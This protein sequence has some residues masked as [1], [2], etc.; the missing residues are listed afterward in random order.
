MSALLCMQTLVFSQA[1]KL[2][3][4]A[5]RTNG[6]ITVDGN[7]NEPEWQKAEVARNFTQTSPRPGE[8]S[9]QKSEVRIL[10]DNNAVYVGATLYDDKQDSVYR[11]LSSRDDDG[12]NVDVF[13]VLFD[14]YYDKQNAAA[15][16]VTAAGVQLDGIIKF[17]G[18]DNSWNAAW[19]SKVVITETGWTVEM[20][21]PYSALRFPSKD[22][23]TWGINFYRGIR[24]Y[25]EASYWSPVKPGVPNK[26]A[27]EGE[28]KGIYN[29]EAPVRLAL[30]PYVSGYAG[31]YAGVNT[32]SINGGLDVK[33]GI[34]ESFTLDMTLVPDFGQTIYDSRVL[35]LSPIEVRYDERRYFFTEGVD[36][37]RKND[38]FY[39]RRVGGAPVNFRNLG[40][41]L[42]TNEVITQNPATTKLYNAT[43]ISGRNKHKLGLG[44]FNAVAAATYATIKDTMTG[45]E[46]MLQ[47]APL[48]NYNVLVMDQALKNNS[49]ISLI[50]TNVYRQE[51]SYN[52]NVSAL[53]FKFANKKNTYGIDGSTD[54][55]HL[56]FT[57]KPDVGYRYY[58]DIAKLSGNY[59]WYLKTR[60]IS[61]RFNP[62][63]LGYLDRNNSVYY[64]FEQY[65][66]I[67]K[68]FGSFI[69][70]YNHVGVNYYR[71]FNPN[72]FQSFDFYGS[73]N[74]TTGK[75]LT[76]GFYWDIAPVTG[77]DYIE[78]RT[79]GRHYLYPRNYMA[80]GFYS[81]D[82]RK[83]FALDLSADNRWYDER[84]RNMLNWAVSPRFRFSDKLSMV[85]NLSGRQQTDDVGF[86][87]KVTDTIYFGI[88][89][90]G[91]ITSS[92]NAAY[93]FTNKMALK[94][95]ARHYWSQAKYNQFKQ[96]GADGALN[97]TTYN[98]VHDVNFNSFNIYT[99]FIWQFKPG[100]EMS[101]VYQN[102]IYTSGAALADNYFSDLNTTLQAA[103]SNSLSV[104]VIY[105]LDYLSLKNAFSKRG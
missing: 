89:N 87:N 98:K 60:T 44:F 63:D 64:I 37:F 59:T 93:I 47:T 71:M 8:P 48:T 18:Q 102:S 15:F 1:P 57:A 56:Y 74:L 45:A 31:N 83:K 92:L 79:F 49:Y 103:Q 100:S 20:K 21:I 5:G 2:K 16:G 36:L 50:N 23:Q 28:L 12:G 61:D 6:N 30:L 38:L 62:N 43:K 22:T 7:L 40:S 10:Y 75:F 19:Y 84:H 42:D 78:P 67:F 73:H 41:Q 14:T 72:V 86:V 27:Q 65:Y 9:L 101:I 80:G 95:D 11:Q 88:R 70:A 55:S 77:S 13:G 51:N 53:M 94:L 99:S 32:Q 39:S 104:K 4:E 35:N 34:N 96:L 33:Y 54:V 66:N 24:R 90:V 76:V 85:Y 26:I 82:Y 25:R 3:L 29:I 91:T 81:T 17:D 58:L 68:P 46:R 69:S 97:T 105:Y 52:A